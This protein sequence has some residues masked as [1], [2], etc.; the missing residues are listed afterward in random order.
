MR[1]P[2]QLLRS[3]RSG[4][5]IGFDRLAERLQAYG[6]AHPQDEAAIGRLATFLS[7]VESEDQVE[8]DK[9]LADSFPASDPPSHSDPVTT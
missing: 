7:F 2:F 1:D 6:R 5:R 4:E 9:A 8:L 3:R